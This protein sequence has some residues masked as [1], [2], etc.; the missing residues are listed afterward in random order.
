[1]LALT[2]LGEIG[3]CE[4]QGCEKQTAAHDEQTRTEDFL[5]IVL[6]EHTYDAYRNH[7]NDDIEEV[8]CLGV[9]LELEESFQNP[10]DFFPQYDEGAEHCCYVHHYG[11]RKVVLALHTE[12]CRADCEVAATTNGQVFCESLDNAKD[13]CL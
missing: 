3:E 7:R 11:E 9:H 10:V 1:M 4:Q 12:E 13:Q 5:D 2:R 8:F 6:E